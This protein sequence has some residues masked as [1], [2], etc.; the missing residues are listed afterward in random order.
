MEKVYW[1][2]GNGLE[3]DIDEMPIEHLRNV[4]K[5]IVK[6]KREN[7]TIS[8]FTKKEIDAIARKTD[9]KIEEEDNLWR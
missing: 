1:K 2:T 7:P 4:L 9:A 3:I 5:F 8:S 6:R